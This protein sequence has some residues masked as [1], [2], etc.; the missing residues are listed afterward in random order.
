MEEIWKDIK[1]YE[2]KYQVSNLGR[3][4]SLN[5]RRMGF[6][7]ILSPGLDGRGYKMAPL[8]ICGKT[9]LL[10]IHRLVAETFIPNHNNYPCVNHIDG[11]KTNN[12]V[13][14]L[15]W[16]TQKYNV[17]HAYVS[18]LITQVKP[19]HCNELDMNFRSMNECARYFDCHFNQIRDV[20]NGR[21]KKLHKKYTFRYI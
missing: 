19:A 5:Y 7:K 17:Q 2:G 11:D 8:T 18:N 21:F 15:E 3:V 20:L 1:G 10:K 16:C 14:N 6:E 12:N 9:K 4:K 13:D